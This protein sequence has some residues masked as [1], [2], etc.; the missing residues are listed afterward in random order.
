MENVSNF[1]WGIAG[2]AG[3]AGILYVLL[4]FRKDGGIFNLPMGMGSR[5]EPVEEKVKIDINLE[6]DSKLGTKKE[7]MIEETDSTQIV[8][9]KVEKIK[10][11]FKLLIFLALIPIVPV[12]SLDQKVGLSDDME[13]VINYLDES[14]KFVELTGKEFQ[15]LRKDTRN[16]TSIK[17]LETTRNSKL[18]EFRIP[19]RE[20]IVK[21]I[22]DKTISATQKDAD[23]IIRKVRVSCVNDNVELELGSRF[24]LGMSFGMLGSVGAHMASRPQPGVLIE[25][26]HWSNDYM[27]IS[28]AVFAG[29]ERY[30]FGA[31]FGPSSYLSNL[32][33]FIGYSKEFSNPNVNFI[34][35]GIAVIA[36]VR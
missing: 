17:V 6:Q 5:K 34:E 10:K 15:D 16:D 21:K 1:V 3:G 26:V 24:W 18:V 29:I 13:E 9:D 11:N 2:A 8:K 19:V 30:G 27:R 20:P 23:P 33:V 7:E 25:G 35:I 14:A 32:R 28:G 12:K 36:Y 4:K 22:N 31:T